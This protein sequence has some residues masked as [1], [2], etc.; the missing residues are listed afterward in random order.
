MAQLQGVVIVTGAASGIGRATAQHLVKCGATVVA[1]DIDAAGLATLEGRGIHVISADLTRNAEC[2]AVAS[3]AAGLGPVRGLFNCA[4]LELH[5]TVVEMPESDWD[6]VMGIN[7]KAIFLLSKHVIPHLV[8]N[9]GGA[10][11]NMSSI[12]AHATSQ[13]VAAYAAT[14]GA[15]LSMTRAMALDHGKDKVRVVAICPG[16]IETPLLRANAASFNPENPEAKIA[17]WAAEHALDRLGQPIEIAKAVA[18]LLSDDASFITG[19]NHLVD[20]GMLASF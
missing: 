1:A 17:E 15:V 18:F 11:V 12:H 4:G 13:Q 2:L 10:V 9:G 5:G 3:F 6:R 19:S 20:G 8:A 14:K 16:A 7:L